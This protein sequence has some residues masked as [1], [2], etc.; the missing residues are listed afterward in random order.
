MER[1]KNRKIPKPISYVCEDYVTSCC[2]ISFCQ[3]LIGLKNG[4]LIQCFFDKNKKIKIERY[5]R[6]HHGKINVIE[7]NKK[8]GLIITSGDDN[9]ILIR[10]WYDFELLSPIKI[11]EKYAITL[12]KVS[13]NNFVYILCYN[14]SKKSNVILGYT[15]NGLKFAESEYGYYNNFD[16]TNNGNIVTLKNN[17]NLCILHG[18][19][20]DYIQMDNTA[21]EYEVIIKIKNAIWLQYDYFIKEEKKNEYV[22]NKIITYINEK[23]TLITL[24]V[25][26]NYFF[27]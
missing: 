26:D 19:N 1:G 15:L 21:P 18:A 20:L 9:Y 6:C 27:N 3:F 14:K 13:P 10:K 22:C 24:D 11:K 23:K 7:V 16:F 4:K 25:S 2:S 12:V 5:I 17:K 8:L